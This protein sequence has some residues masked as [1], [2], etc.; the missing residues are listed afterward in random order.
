MAILQRPGFGFVHPDDL[1]TLQAFRARLLREPATPLTIELRA[2]H[3]E[4]ESQ[5]H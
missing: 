5:P 3:R 1:P 2:L 4:F